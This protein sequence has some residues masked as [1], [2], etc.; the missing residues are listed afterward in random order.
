MIS[1]EVKQVLLIRKDLKNTEGHKIRTGKVVAQ[2]CHASEA[3]LFG[4]MTI[5]PE[6]RMGSKGRYIGT[7]R[8]INEDIKIWIEQ[9]HKKVALAVHSEDDLVKRYEEAVAAGLVAHIIVD[10]GLTEFG[11]I[12][13]K[14]AVAIGPANAEDINKITGDLKPL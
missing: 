9:G 6:G 14:T 5:T 3:W 8:G 11:G 4:M 7:V 13:T 1:N 10:A 2:S 12:E